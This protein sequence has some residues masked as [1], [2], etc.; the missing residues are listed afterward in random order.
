MNSPLHSKTILI[1]TISILILFLGLFLGRVGALGPVKD[2]AIKITS[3]FQLALQGAGRGI[4]G[5]FNILGSINKLNQ[6]NQELKQANAELFSENVLLKELKKENALLRKQL[7]F[8]KRTNFKLLDAEV[9]NRNPASPLQYL[10]LNRGE[11]DGVKKNLGVTLNGALVGVISDAN[12]YTSTVLLIT[13]QTSIINAYIQESRAGGVV[14]G[15][16]GYGLKMELIP[17][18]KVVKE[19]DT[20]ITSALGGLLPKGI[21]IGTV[22]KVE[23][24]ESEIFQTAT[25]KP[26]IN[27]KE[28]ETV[29]VIL[30]QS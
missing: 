13:D 21:I 12:Y 19:G 1:I 11:K 16:L 3:P 18:D 5:F 27:F 15:Q 8:K 10:T 25:I 2:I 22:D 24:A 29:F 7:G 23:K 30:A 6:E 17:Q 20:I 4:A 26:T 14:K 9:I 28:I